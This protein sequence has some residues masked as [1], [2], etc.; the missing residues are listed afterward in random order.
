MIKRLGLALFAVLA[1]TAAFA[2]TFAPNM[3]VIGGNSYCSSTVNASCVNT[4]PAGP[5]I[6]GN[7]VVPADVNTTISNQTPSSGKISLQTLGVGLNTYIDGTANATATA[8]TRRIIIAASGTVSAITI[9]TPAATGLLEGQL[10][11]LCTTQIVSTL[12]VTAG[13]GTTVSN[14]PTAMIVPV[15]TG[16]ASCVGWIYRLSNTTWYRIQ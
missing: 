13:S 11:G 2:Q 9:T 5:A 4:V 12:T 15:A 6:T 8:Q 10:F 1:T 3:P 16:A 7:E 14:A